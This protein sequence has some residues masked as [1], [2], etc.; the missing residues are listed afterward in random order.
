[1]KLTM[2]LWKPLY[3]KPF[4]LFPACDYGFIVSSDRR[5]L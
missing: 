1:M 5:L 4:T 2:F 3:Q